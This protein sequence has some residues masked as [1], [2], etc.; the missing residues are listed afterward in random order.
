MCYFELVFFISVI[1]KESEDFW[2]KLVLVMMIFVFMWCSWVYEV[3]LVMK[4]ELSLWV[5]YLVV[6]VKYC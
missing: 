4:F 5:N 3:V 2:S 6:V 1:L